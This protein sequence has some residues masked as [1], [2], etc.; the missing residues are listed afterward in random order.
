MPS[1]NV[2][3]V[4]TTNTFEEWRVKSNEIGTAIGDLHE[5]DDSSTLPY[6]TVIDALKGI[7]AELT[8]NPNHIILYD[9]DGNQVFPVP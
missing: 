5:L 7:I 8:T 9:E 2:V 6:A 1:P 3:D 4:S